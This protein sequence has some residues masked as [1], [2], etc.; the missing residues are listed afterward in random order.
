MEICR[1]RRRVVDIMANANMDAVDGRGQGSNFLC[2]S[3]SLLS[4]RGRTT[5]SL[6][7]SFSFSDRICLQPSTRQNWIVN[8]QNY[9]CV[10]TLSL[11]RNDFMGHLCIL[12]PAQLWQSKTQLLVLERFLDPTDGSVGNS[13]EYSPTL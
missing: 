9:F 7:L 1:R 12:D 8:L 6:S 5:F 2:K 11:F 4:T 13:R 10:H 3:I